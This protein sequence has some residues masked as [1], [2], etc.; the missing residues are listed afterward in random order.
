M[1][2]RF[3][4]IQEFQDANGYTIDG[5]WYPRV[6]KIVTIKAKPALYHFYGQADSF[7]HGEAIKEKSAEEGTKIHEAVEG[8]LLGQEPEIDWEI[9]PAVSAFREFL[10]KRDIQTRPEHV[11]QRVCHS[12]HRYAGT[13][14]ALA[15]INGKFGVLDIKTSLS[16]YRD[17]NLQ[18]AAYLEALKNEYDNLETRWIL[19][20]DQGQVCNRCGAK[21]RTKGGR[22]KIR[23]NG[24]LTCGDGEHEWGEA[25]GEIELKEFPSWRSDFE[26]FLGAKR[27]WEWE[28]ED[29]LKKIGYL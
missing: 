25:K 24:Y 2:E 18:T 21:L 26:G 6:T 23:R 8:I 27:L 17:Y 13:V 4:T 5:T 11:E 15:V 22:E 7:A 19:R 20:I 1:F 9:L 12:E 28:N 16:I 29:W 14:D 3:S 10:A